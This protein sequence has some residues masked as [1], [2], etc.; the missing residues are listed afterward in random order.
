MTAFSDS[1]S[2]RESLFFGRARLKF[3]WSRLP[4]KANSHDF[5][6]RH[7]IYLPEWKLVYFFVPKVACTSLK[8]VC[9]DL[10][11]LSEDKSPHEHSFPKLDRQQLLA[12]PSTYDS[13][14]VVRD[15]IDRLLSGYKSMVM[16]PIHDRHYFHGV[17]RPLVKFGGFSHAMSFEA[18]CRRVV[19]IPDR[20]ADPHFR[21][22]STCF[23]TS[24]GEI[25]VKRCF[26][27]EQ[28]ATEI[29]AYLQSVTGQPIALPMRNTTARLNS[30]P[31]LSAECR[32]LLKLRFDT[33][34]GLLESLPLTH[35]KSA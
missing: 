31:D 19:E 12:A 23:T 11:S 4:W 6:Y 14:A 2:L 16:R 25:L 9:A 15:P 28:L 24:N 26:R 34:Y 22:Q 21:S 5:P 30:T 18:F 10:L 3:A 35:K 7:H 20:Y 27:F 17:F 13:F 8:T 29:P 33:D 32:Q 1:W